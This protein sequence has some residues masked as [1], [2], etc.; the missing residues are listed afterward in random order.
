MPLAPR[1]LNNVA[2]TVL[3]SIQY[4]YSQKT[5]GSNR[6][7]QTCFLPWVPSNIG[8]PLLSS[9]AILIVLC[10]RYNINI[11]SKCRWGMNC[12]ISALRL[13]AIIPSIFENSAA[14]IW[15]S[16][17]S[18]NVTRLALGWIVLV[19][20]WHLFSAIVTKQLSE[21]IFDKLACL[22]LCKSPIL[23]KRAVMVCPIFVANKSCL[24][25]R[26]MR[27]KWVYICW[28]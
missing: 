21:S 16:G 10:N 28:F 17:P 14:P 22:H 27:Q 2:S 20:G 5:L 9:L 7:H 26:N 4:I 11:L 13:Y 1:S 15:C 8:T 24:N 19:V 18:L 23:S 6:G 25:F 3:S 12:E